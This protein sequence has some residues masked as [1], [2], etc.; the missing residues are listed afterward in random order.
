MKLDG[1]C[2]GSGKPILLC[3]LL[4][5]GAR[6]DVG[7]EAAAWLGQLLAL[8]T[9][10]S[11]GGLGPQGERRSETWAPGVRGRSE[12]HGKRLSCPRGSQEVR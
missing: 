5:G 3:C 8:V 1:F 11:G 4:P 6:W 7:S 2:L 9:Q 10:G 12:G